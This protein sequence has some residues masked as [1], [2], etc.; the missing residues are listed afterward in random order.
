M[1]QLLKDIKP[2]YLYLIVMRK[3]DLENVKSLSETLD[4]IYKTF[5][6]NPTK[7]NL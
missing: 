2:S 1:K 3:S 6:E 4:S 7:D 5:K